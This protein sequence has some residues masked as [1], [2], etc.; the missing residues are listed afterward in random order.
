MV[1][2]Y[3]NIKKES[4]LYSCVDEFYEIEI[5]VPPRNMIMAWNK[6]KN[7]QKNIGYLSFPG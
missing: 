5:L 2:L 4:I 7:V 1:L 6:V 3:K